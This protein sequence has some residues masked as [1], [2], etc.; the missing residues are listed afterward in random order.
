VIFEVMGGYDL[1]LT[2]SVISSLTGMGSVTLLDSLE[3]LIIPDW[4]LEPTIVLS[5]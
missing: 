1:T 5:D 2:I 3:K 4:E